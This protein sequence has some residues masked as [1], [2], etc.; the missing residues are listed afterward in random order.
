MKLL[1]LSEEVWNDK[2]YPNN[3]MTN[4]FEGFEGELANLYLASGTPDNP[5]CS[6]YFQITDRMAWKNLFRKGSGGRWFVLQNTDTLKT[7]LSPIKY[8]RVRKGIKLALGGMLRLLRDAVWLRTRWEESPLMDFLKAFKP[9]IIFSLRFSS[10]RMLHMERFLYSVTGAPVIAFTGDD[11][12]SL[13]QINPSP[14]YW[15][16]RLLLRRDI[17]RTAGIYGKYYTLSERQAAEL[18]KALGVKSGVIYKGGNFPNALEEKRISNPIRMVYAGRLY[19]NRDRTLLSVAKAVARINRKEVKI[20]LEIYTRDK[21]GRRGRDAFHDGKSVFLKGFVSAENLRNIYREADIALLAESFDLRN[22]LLTRY[23]FST[24]I[25]DCLASTCA[26]IAVGPFENEGIRY[27]KKNRGAV[28]IGKKEEIYSV[29]SHIVSHPDK[30]EVY[31]SNA[32]RLGMRAHR[33]EDIRQSLYRD[34]AS[35]VKNV[36]EASQV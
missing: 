28:C 13:K 6:E 30:I 4:W 34:I 17:R 14:F 5:C 18:G 1:V 21:P 29:L 15:I 31:R 35:I 26:V 2:L 3:V 7:K 16:R 10:R 24:K 19:C 20:I 36:S 12:Y 25:V 27:L 9:D 22:R 8:P 23:S 32:W 33:K 11:E